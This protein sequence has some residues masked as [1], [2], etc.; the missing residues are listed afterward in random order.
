MPQL[1][2]NEKSPEGAGINCLLFYES[3]THV[4]AEAGQRLREFGASSWLGLYLVQ[5]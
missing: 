5:T 1:G 2:K 4:K 3:L